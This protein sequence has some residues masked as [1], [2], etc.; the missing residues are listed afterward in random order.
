MEKLLPEIY[1]YVSLNED[2]YNN[3]LDEAFDFVSSGEIEKSIAIY[4]YLL[5]LNNKDLYVLYELANSCFYINYFED[6]IIL[7]KI[8]IEEDKDYSDISHLMIGKCYRKTNQPAKAIE[9]FEDALIKYPDYK[10][11]LILLELA[12]VY[13]DVEDYFKS[14]GIFESLIYLNT[15][16]AQVCFYYISLILV[17]EGRYKEAVEFHKKISCTQTFFSYY[18]ELANLYLKCEDYQNA[19]DSYKK[20]LEIE[21]ENLKCLYRLGNTYQ[22]SHLYEEAIECDLRLYNLTAG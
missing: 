6:A 11:N 19:I 22:V 5:D 7:Y 9:K 20:A 8:I 17:N 18:Y 10:C 16:Y 13:Y 12:Q 14:K 21:P 1:D 3:L 15:G 4:S 2:I